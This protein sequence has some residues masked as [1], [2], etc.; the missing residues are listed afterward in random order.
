[1]TAIRRLRR[2]ELVADGER[3]PA[4]HGLDGALR[5]VSRLDAHRRVVD[6]DPRDPHAPARGRTAGTSRPCQRRT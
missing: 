5:R 1:M 6:R 3:Q 4:A 2:V